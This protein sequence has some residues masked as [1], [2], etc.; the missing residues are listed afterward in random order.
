MTIL[1]IVWSNEKDVV[2]EI[3]V[4]KSTHNIL[5]TLDRGR[6]Y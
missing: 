4:Q 1:R 5:E 2:I 6:L 3:L